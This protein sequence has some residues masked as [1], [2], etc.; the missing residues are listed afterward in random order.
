MAA[1]SNDKA[2]LL[3]EWR[4]AIFPSMLMCMR[5]AFTERLQIFSFQSGVKFC[6]NMFPSPSQVHFV[7]VSS[8]TLQRRSDFARL[9]AE[10]SAGEAAAQDE[11]DRFSAESAEDKAVKQTDSTHKERTKSGKE[12]DLTEAQK[13][14]KATQASTAAGKGKAALGTPRETTAGGRRAVFCSFLASE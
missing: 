12:Q 7:V 11:Y 13:D 14:L 5:R 8:L 1:L 3:G 9:E 4:Y 10:T 2:Y 6:F